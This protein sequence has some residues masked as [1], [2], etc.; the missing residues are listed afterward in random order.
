MI[1]RQSLVRPVVLG[2]RSSKFFRFSVEIRACGVGILRSLYANVAPGGPF[3]M[4]QRLQ[5]FLPIVLVALVVQIFAP[6]GASWA[7]AAAVGDP[8]RLGEI[9]H[10]EAVSI[11]QQD[12]QNGDPRVH[13]SY[14]WLCC[15]AQAGASLDTPKLATVAVPYRAAAPVAWCDQ[16]TGPARELSGSNAQA[17]APPPLM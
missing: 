15:A 4:R 9:C 1:L 12:D 7:A 11:P 16:A 10:S 13:E 2:S 5:R 3:M 8:L 6:I 17:R 14:C